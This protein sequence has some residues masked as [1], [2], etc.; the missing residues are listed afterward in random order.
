MNAF[1]GTNYT[2]KPFTFFDTAH[3]GA[4]LVIFLLNIFLL[5]YRG[6][7]ES[8]RYKVRLT[9]AIIL[10]AN[11]A[12]WH[13]WNIAYGTWSIQEHLPLHACSVLIWLAGFMLIKKNYRI[14]EFAYLLGIGGALQALLTPD[15]GIYGFPHFR[16]FQTY[17]SHGLLVTSA[18]Y[19]TVVEGMRPT[20]KSVL[21]VAVFSN[22]YLI[23]M[24]GVNFLIG[25]NYMFVA[26]KPAGPTV[27]DALPAWPWYIL[28]ME[29]MGLVMFLLL[30]LP[31][32]IKDWLAKKKAV[33]A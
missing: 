5:R 28:Y 19:M 18:I 22:L 27:L 26:H 33:A 3:I 9:M 24:F 17:I 10:W 23:V 25:S 31:F 2:G 15:I 8:V 30:Y 12:A 7:D 11:E 13:L 6:K 16:F 1:F 32:A 20:W 14:Y 21:R 4:L 29:A